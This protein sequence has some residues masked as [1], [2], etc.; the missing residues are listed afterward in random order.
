MARSGLKPRAVLRAI[1]A[2]VAV[3]VLTAGPAS[4]WSAAFAGAAAPSAP[5]PCQ[6][7]DLGI[8]VPGAIGGDPD[9]G[10]GKRAWN[11]VFR[12][13][14]K[15]T[16]SLRGWPQIVVRTTAGKTI[17]TTVSNV[18]YSNLAPA[19]DTEI[20]LPPGQSAIVTAPSPTAPP[21]PAPP[22]APALTPPPP[23]P[24]APL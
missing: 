19:P 1:T 11:I 20:V 4:G 14:S 8:S 18:N 13:T 23:P 17:A 3:V 2:A 22:C 21:R 12:N 6:A 24:P 16:C 5:A 15:T 7:T 9:E 10:M